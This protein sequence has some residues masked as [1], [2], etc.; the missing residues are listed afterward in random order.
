MQ[1]IIDRTD[2]PGFNKTLKEEDLEESWNMYNTG[3][4]GINPV[5][6]DSYS[7]NRFSND[8]QQ[9]EIFELYI[10]DLAVFFV[11]NQIYKIF[12]IYLIYNHFTFP[13]NIVLLE[14]NYNIFYYR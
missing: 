10:C 8:L 13:G 5:V 7:Y 11:R 3:V 12:G 14:V 6:T 9:P 1:A 2:V 4:S